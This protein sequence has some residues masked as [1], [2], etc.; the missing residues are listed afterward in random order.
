MASDR[1]HGAKMGWLALGG[2]SVIVVCLLFPL[3]STLAYSV[4]VSTADRELA[5]TPQNYSGYDWHKYEA[6]NESWDAASGFYLDPACDTDSTVWTTHMNFPF[7]I[8]TNPSS[9]TTG[10]AQTD[11]WTYLYP[12][13]KNLQYS[14]PAQQVAC[15]TNGA[16]HAVQFPACIVIQC[17][18]NNDH[19]RLSEFSHML[20]RGPACLDNTAVWGG[21]SLCSGDV[22]N[23]LAA[24]D[25]NY[26]VIPQDTFLT[27]D[28]WVTLNGVRV[29]GV[30]SDSAPVFY[31]GSYWALGG[32]WVHS[33][34]QS[35]QIAHQLSASE[36]MT[37]EDTIDNCASSAY[38]CNGSAE[39]VVWI[40]NVVSPYKMC[41]TGAGCVEG[42]T[43]NS[44]YSPVNW[45]Q[46][47]NA[48]AGIDPYDL[49]WVKT[50][51][52]MIDPSGE[53]I[54]TANAFAWGTVFM[55]MAVSATPF[56]N[57]IANKLKERRANRGAP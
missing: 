33:F 44:Y 34:W 25:P 31:N 21:A 45:N 39:A 48:P 37:L 24:G 57:P 54:I 9:N 42:N 7:Q 11:N 53:L 30:S 15:Q 32:Q 4:A 14:F 55:F 20:I 35:L 13:Y 5:T 17:D 36:V 22:S 8:G 43:I 18:P 38:G 47:G 40:D 2:L 10:I 3:T 28:W 51:S 41:K 23:G 12:P 16:L 19:T 50:T 26:E 49:A 27:F 52:Q 29:F 1:W 6:T 56:Y 46:S